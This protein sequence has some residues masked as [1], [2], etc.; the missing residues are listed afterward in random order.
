M[1][2]VWET[3]IIV[4]PTFKFLSD[5]SHE[6]FS[7]WKLTVRKLRDRRQISLL[8]LSEFNPFSTSASLTD[9]LG[10]LVFTSK[11]FEKHLWKSD[12]LSKDTVH[13]PA[14]LLK[15]SLF[16]RCFSN[17]LLLKV[18]YLVSTQVEHWSKMG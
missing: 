7:V 10:K 6:L 14:S 2:L 13:G 9:K 3:G 4:F 15:M 11:M 12:I 18:K 8:I 5:F 16:N 1:C 17:I